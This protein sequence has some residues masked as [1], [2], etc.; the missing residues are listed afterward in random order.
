MLKDKQIVCTYQ[1]KFGFQIPKYSVAAQARKWGMKKLFT[2]KNLFK[3]S[4]KATL[5]LKKSPTLDLTRI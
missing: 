1:K 2:L 4:E 5:N 3:Y